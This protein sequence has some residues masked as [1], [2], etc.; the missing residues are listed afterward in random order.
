MTIEKPVSTIAGAFD[1]NRY[2]ALCKTLD[3]AAA[4]GMGRD[5]VTMF[6]G[7][8]L[9]ISFGTYLREY[10]DSRFAGRGHGSL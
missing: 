8:E 9:L 5:E 10:L 2:N 7:Q 1:R 6:E 4:E 3:E